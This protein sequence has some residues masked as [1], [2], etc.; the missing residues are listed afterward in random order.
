M[1]Y[2]NGTQGHESKDNE[3]RLPEINALRREEIT[4]TKSSSIGRK[5]DLTQRMA[6][7]AR[8]VRELTQSNSSKKNKRNYRYMTAKET[9]TN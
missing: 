2:K 9:N 3:D 5:E 1:D 4:T 7:Q 6:E 8:T